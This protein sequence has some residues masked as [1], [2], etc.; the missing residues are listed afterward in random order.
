MNEHFANL[1]KDNWDIQTQNNN[2]ACIMDTEDY[3]EL[4]EKVTK[5]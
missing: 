3:F 4:F 2:P 1:K 5:K